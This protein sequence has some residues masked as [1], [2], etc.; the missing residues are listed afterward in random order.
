MIG[1]CACFVVGKYQRLDYSQT[2]I[3]LEFAIQL[4]VKVTVVCLCHRTLNLRGSPYSYY[5]VLN[6]SPY[7]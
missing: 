2:S 4:I 7:F 6:I 5:E 1:T 3:A